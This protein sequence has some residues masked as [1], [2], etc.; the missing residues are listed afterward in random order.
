MRILSLRKRFMIPNQDKVYIDCWEKI[1]L[2]SY[3]PSASIYEAFCLESAQNLHAGERLREL[4]EHTR[5]KSGDVGST[6][7]LLYFSPSNFLL[8]VTKLGFCP[9][10]D[11]RKQV[12]RDL[13][14]FTRN[15]LG[16]S[17]RH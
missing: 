5:L 8:D 14:R 10:K 1:F 7:L 16:L 11:I 15:I 2:F 13:V 6:P 17:K 9:S 4:F 12:P 3:I